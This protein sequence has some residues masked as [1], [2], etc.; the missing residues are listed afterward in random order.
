MKV[1]L[2]RD[3][4]IGN[5]IF[6]YLVVDRGIIDIYEGIFRNTLTGRIFSIFDVY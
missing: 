1:D 4:G 6:F 2:V 3:F 5:N